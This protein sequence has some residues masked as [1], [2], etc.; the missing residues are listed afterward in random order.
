MNI[1]PPSRDSSPGTDTAQSEI[2]F[3]AVPDAAPAAEHRL[4]SAAIA[5]TDG[6][7]ARLRTAREARG[8]DMQQCAQALHLPVHVLRKLEAENFGA[9]DT[10]VFLRGALGSYARLLGVPPAAV[11]AAMPRVATQRLPELVPTG[12]TPRGRWLLQ[13]YGAVAT[14]LALTATVAVPLVWLGL[15]GGLDNHLTEI[16]PLDGAAAVAAVQ[17]NALPAHA[18]TQPAAT[19]AP[20]HEAPLQASMTPF[21]AMDIPLLNQGGASTTPQ[22]AAQPAAPAAATHPGE[23][24]LTLSASG[25]CWFEVT[26]S[27]G[28][29]LASGMLHAGDQRSF[30]ST[31]PLDVRVGNVAAVQITGDGQ[32]IELASR[33]RANVADFRAFAAGNAE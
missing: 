23:H 24:V 9:A 28:S 15:R 13:R 14:Y 17:H 27:D 1:N 33:Q 26:A 5:P 30:H 7:G 8:M 4:E 29:K 31:G 21:A 18:T 10:H 3:G 20:L 16:A 2:R 32:P 25:D 6:I 11:D 19:P 22:A 12:A